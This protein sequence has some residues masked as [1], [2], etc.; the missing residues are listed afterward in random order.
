MFDGDVQG[1]ASTTVVRAGHHLDGQVPARTTTMPFRTTPSTN[2]RDTLKTNLSETLKLGLKPLHP[3]H[4]EVLG[5]LRDL[6]EQVS[7]ALNAD[8]P[9]SDSGLHVRCRLYFGGLTG[10][11]WRYL[12]YL[13]MFDGAGSYVQREQ[14]LSVAVSDVGY[15]VEV[16]PSLECR[17]GAAL[18]SALTEEVASAYVQK[19]LQKYQRRLGQDRPLPSEYPT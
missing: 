3:D 19:I 2:L 17:N 7:N 9:E 1:S 5:L 15:P 16:C 12:V 6:T 10:S 11:A 4:A 14:L 18:V 8:A 13:E